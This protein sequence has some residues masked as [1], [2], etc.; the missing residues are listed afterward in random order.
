MQNQ[1]RPLAFLV[2][3]ALLAGSQ[4]A[5]AQPRDPI[6]PSVMTPNKVESRIGTL[7]FADG[8]PS[9]QTLEKVFDNLDFMHAVRAF[10]DT[11]QGVSIQAVRKGLQS[12]GVKDHEV[13]VFSNLMDSKS[14]FLTA[15]ADTIYII[16][17]F[18]LTKGPV[19]IE[20]PPQ[21]LGTVQDAW[22]RWIVD[23]GLPGPDRGKGGKYLI[24]PPGYKGA[25]PESG[26]AIGHSAHRA[27][28][29]V[30]TRIP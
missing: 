21:V 11:L 24:V 30:R 12:V 27:R 5:G 10:T 16:G 7:E 2:A 4:L 20:V 29:V 17:S 23:V 15:N 1:L 13:I 28:R 18:D 14:L 6:P 3:G 19:V 25:L 9:K 22:F 26:Y 8:A